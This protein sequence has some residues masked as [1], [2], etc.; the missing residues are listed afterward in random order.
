MAVPTFKPSTE[1]ELLTWSTNFDAKITATPTTFGLTADQAT[2]YAALHA[3]F[4]TAYATAV[5]PNTNS[6]QAIIAKNQAK[7][8]L[9]NGEGGARDLVSIIQVFPDTTDAMRGE[10]GLRIHDAEPTPVPEPTTPPDLSIVSTFART[11]TVRLRDQKNPDRRGKPDGVQGAT[12]LYHVG[13]TA[14]ADAS[15]WIFAKNTSRTSFNVEVPANVEAGSRVWLTAFWF[16]TR[17]ESGPAA[18]P[19]STR[20]SD[21]FAQSRAA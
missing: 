1:A 20:I 12:I 10:L 21:G 8:K 7:T 9:L 15:Q 3:A 11:I 2:A 16:N 13:D 17:K 4:A 18:T 5:N 6:K 14:P 19:E